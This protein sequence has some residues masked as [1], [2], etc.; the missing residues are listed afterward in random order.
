MT[1]TGRDFVTLIGTLPL[2][3]TGGDTLYDRIGDAFG[4]LCLAIALALVGGAAF[5]RRRRIG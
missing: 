5:E 1:P 3:G 4:W 2:A